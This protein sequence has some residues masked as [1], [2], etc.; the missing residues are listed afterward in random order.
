MNSTN[1][2][3][4]ASL[5]EDQQVRRV[6]WPQNSILTTIRRGSHEIVPS[7]DTLIV[8]GDLLIFTI[9]SDASGEI[10][11]KLIALTQFLTENS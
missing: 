9:P 1:S 3:L 8:A 10:R 11:P 6:E 5:A 7:G 2:S 4:R